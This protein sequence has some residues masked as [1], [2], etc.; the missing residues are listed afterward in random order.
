MEE[1]LKA[2]A[3][4]SSVSDKDDHFHHFAKAFVVLLINH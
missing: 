2:L 4:L 1:W 3:L